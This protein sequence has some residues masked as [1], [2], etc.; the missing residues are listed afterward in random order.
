MISS[1]WKTDSEGKDEID[2]GAGLLPDTGPTAGTDM[3]GGTDTVTRGL[4]TAP[5]TGFI[6]TGPE[7]DPLPGFDQ[8]RGPGH[9]GSKAPSLNLR[10]EIVLTL[11]I[12]RPG[13]FPPKVGGDQN[14]K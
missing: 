6:D 13:L 10:E 7:I 11:G 4:G 5:G 1:L 9:P 14:M 3:A 2:D 12:V 8:D